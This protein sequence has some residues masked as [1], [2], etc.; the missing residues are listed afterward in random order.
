MSIDDAERGWWYASVYGWGARNAT[1]NVLAH[2]A[3]DGHPIE[4][5]AGLPQGGYAGSGEFTY[6][7]IYPPQEGGKI[8]VSVTA[9]SSGF[10]ERRAAV[11]AAVHY[12]LRS[13]YQ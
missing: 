7:Q 1:Y 12:S 10:S 6:Y 11:E 13:R 3:S 2:D 5:D 8:T 9:V 4:L